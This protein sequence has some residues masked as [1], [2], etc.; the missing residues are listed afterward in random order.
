MKPSKRLAVPQTLGD[1]QALLEKERESQQDPKWGEI[2]TDDYYYED[3]V[4]LSKEEAERNVYLWDRKHLFTSGEDLEWLFAYR[5]IYHC[6]TV[7]DV[8][9]KIERNNQNQHLW[10]RLKGEALFY[11]AKHHLSIT[12]IWAQAYDLNTANSELGIPLRLGVDFNEVS[13]RSSLE[14]TYQQI[15]DDLSSASVLLPDV[16]AHVVRPS[17]AAAYALL[18][19]THLFM[20]NYPECLRNANLCLQI[21]D[22]LI[23]YNDLHPDVMFPFSIFNNEVIY[24]SYISTGLVFGKPSKELLGMYDNYDLRK[25]LFFNEKVFGTYPFSGSY[26]GRG[27]LFSGIAV[28]EIYLM[29]AECLARVGEVQNAIDDLNTLLE[30][31]IK[32]GY[33]VPYSARSKEE[34]V[35]LILNERRK[36]LVFRGLRWPDVKRLNREGKGIIMKR[37]H[38]ETEIVLEPNDLRY[39][40]SIPQGIVDLTGIPQNPR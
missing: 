23:D 39:A 1:L 16:P 7:L 38:L 22:D 36:Q 40:L 34:V 27:T 26:Y 25:E 35:N 14:D 17:K 12:N 15:L 13:V 30:K 10:D 37:N 19:R 20:R 31:R 28:D 24:H 29:R 9:E 4:L 21:K 33:F 8:L 6:N 18:A 3:D 2:G 11:R 5:F 32:H